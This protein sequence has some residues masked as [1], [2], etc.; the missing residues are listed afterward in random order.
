MAQYR[1]GTVSVT[2]GSATVTGSGTLWESLTLVDSMIFK[3]KDEPAIYYIDEITDDTTIV[4][5][6]EYLGTTTSGLRYLIVQDYTV[7][8]GFPV[9][10]QGD[11]NWSGL[12]SLAIHQL[13][14]TVYNGSLKFVRFE[15]LDEGDVPAQSGVLYFD[16]TT[17]KFR[18]HNGTAFYTLAVE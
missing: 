18:Y 7:N 12:L 13:D 8:Y 16:D 14:N 6:Q 2:N 3:I 15:A 11:V 17:K 10:R 5:N 1:T 9:I 4:L